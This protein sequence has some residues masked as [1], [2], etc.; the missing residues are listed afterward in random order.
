V[1]LLRIKALLGLLVRHASSYVELAAAAAVEYRS[2]LARRLLLLAVGLVTAVAGLLAA[3]A[4]GLVALWNTPWRL[5][6]VGG[7]ALLLLVVAGVTLYYALLSRPAG[8]SSRVLR[9]E[10]EKDMELLQEWKH[11]L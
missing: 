5:A 4:T 3:W 10:L 1:N 7:S 9:S 8:P 6:Y 11:S 2:A